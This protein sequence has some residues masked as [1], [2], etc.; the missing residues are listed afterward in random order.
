MGLCKDRHIC[1][2]GFPYHTP[3]HFR[4]KNSWWG[5]HIVDGICSIPVVLE[6][7]LRQQVIPPCFKRQSESGS[8]ILLR[9]R[10]YTSRKGAS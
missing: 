2:L 8:A 9:K 1:F 7:A 10:I 3:M 6:G 4:A 5:D